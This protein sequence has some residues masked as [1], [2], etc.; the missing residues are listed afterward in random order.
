LVSQDSPTVSDHGRF[1][2]SGP[3]SRPCAGNHC[4]VR[5]LT[6]EFVQNTHERVL[7]EKNSGKLSASSDATRKCSVVKLR[8]EQLT[9]RTPPAFFVCRVCS[10][11]ADRVGVVVPEVVSYEANGKDARGV[12]YSP[13]R[14]SCLTCLHN[15]CHLTPSGDKTQHRPKLLVLCL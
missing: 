12:D 6:V 10:T 2:A 11:A 4:R 9:P 3:V 7:C 5:S 14:A 8:D 15:N 13:P 1:K